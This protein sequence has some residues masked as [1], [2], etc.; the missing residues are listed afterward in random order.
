MN[1]LNIPF[2]EIRNLYSQIELEFPKYTTQIINLA[3]QNAQGTRPKVVGQMSELIET[4]KGKSIEEWETWYFEQHPESI[5]VATDKVFEMVNKLKEAVNKIDREMVRQYIHELVITKT[6]AGFRF[7]KA[8]LIKIAEEEGVGYR[9]ASPEDEA[10][11]IDGYID[12]QPVSIKPDTYKSKRL[13]LNEDI[14]VAII[15]YKKDNN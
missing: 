2:A 3:N 15:F 6:Y 5:D 13:T 8:I 7:Q 14:Q 10:K 1:T 11:G 4:F 12:D 9:L